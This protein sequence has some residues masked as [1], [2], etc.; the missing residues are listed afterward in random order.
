MCPHRTVTTRPSNG[1]YFVEPKT[2]RQSQRAYRY[3]LLLELRKKGAARWTRRRVFAK[4]RAHRHYSIARNA[5]D[6]NLDQ[7]PPVEIRL[8]HVQG[9]V[10]PPQAGL[11]EG[12]LGS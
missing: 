4:D 6:A 9:H 12:M 7:R 2:A 5:L 10:S 8:H 11:E 3:R 1:S